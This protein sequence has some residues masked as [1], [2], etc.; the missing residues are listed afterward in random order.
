LLGLGAG[1]VY[2]LIALGVVLVYR[3][4]G[5]LN[6]AQG[7][8][9]MTGAFMF[10]DLQ[11]SAGWPL[12]AAAVAAAMFSAAL[13]I[14]I[15]LL[16]MRRLRDSSGLA[17]LIA[18]LA[19]WLFLRG[20]AGELWGFDA[21]LPDRILPSSRVSLLNTSVGADRLIVCGVAIALTIVLGLVYRFTRF[22]IA[23]EAVAE[24]PVASAALGI[25]PHFL[26]S[27]N[28]ALGS[29]LA[30][31][32]A[33]LIVPISGLQVDDLTFLVIPGLAAALVG[34][35]R[36]YS[37]TLLG[38]LAL[39]IAESETSRYVSDPGWTR[40][41]PF[42]V[43]VLV[44]VIRGRALPVRGEPNVRA[45]EV[46][47][48]RI[49][50]SWLAVGIAGVALVIFVA[51]DDWTA[52]LITTFSVGLVVLSIV[53][54]TGYC[55]QLSLAQFAVAGMGAWAAGRLVANYG[56]PMPVAALIAVV[57]AVPVGLVIAV[58]A[59]RTR[60][61]NL[62]VAT[63]GLA[64]VIE[65]LVLLNSKRTGGIDGTRVGD[66]KLFG[67]D[68]SGATHP[69][70]YAALAGVVFLLAAVGVANVRRGPSGRRYIAVRAN[71]R[72]AAA[73]GI[74][75]VETKMFAFAIAA[76]IA[77]LGGVLAAFRYPLVT[78]EQFSLFQSIYAVVVAVLGGVG[79][80][81]GSLLGATL[82]PG[83]IGT[84]IGDSL[85][86]SIETQLQ[87]ITPLVLLVMLRREPNGFAKQ[88]M[89][90]LARLRRLTRRGV[91]P[92]DVPPPVAARIESRP[93]AHRGTPTETPKSLQVEGLSVS[94]G[95]TRALENVSFRVTPG[96]VVG[97]IGANGAGK[98]TLIDA[99]TGFVKPSQGTVVLGDVDI[100]RWSPDRRARAGVS[101]SFQ[102]LELFDSLS[103]RDNLHVACDSATRL[104]FLTDLVHPARQS[105]SST[106][107]EAIDDFGLG[108]TLDRRPDDLPYAT[109]RLVAIARAVATSPSVLLLD[110]PA[111]GLDDA[112][113]AELSILIRRLAT[114]WRLAVIVVEHDMSLVLK[115]CDRIEVLD[116]GRH[117]ASGTPEEIRHDQ[118]VLDAYLGAAGDDASERGA[119][120][121]QVRAP[122]ARENCERD[123]TS[124][125]SGA[126]VLH[127]VHVSAG[128][129]DLAAVR[130]VDLEVHA[131]E[132]VAIIGSNGAGKTTT[133]RALAGE[134]P[135]LAGEIRWNDRPC[136]GPM[137]QRARRGLAF[138]PEGR[139]VFVNLSVAANLR[140]G[141]GQSADALALFPELQALLSRR[142]GLL[143]GG[144][145][146]ILSVARALAS[147][148]S[149]LLADELSIGLAPKIVD[150]LFAEIRR[151]ADDGVAAI[152]VDQS[153]ERVLDIAD[154]VVVLS[155]GLVV[156]NEPA[157]ALRG[158]TAAI[159]ESFLGA[160]ERDQIPTGRTVDAQDARSR[161]SAKNRD[162]SLDNTLIV[163]TKSTN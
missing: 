22:G 115:T 87:I 150:R 7:A 95:H 84:Q 55:G 117:L 63:L 116:Q 141:R 17:A 51:S 4:S 135:L 25:S 18:T 44:L 137:H 48:G 71:E 47:T 139:S 142:G 49:S 128:Y 130:D 112:E 32:G 103:V 96:E 10:Y 156:A 125:A 163:E 132:I 123:S 62:A 94:F 133:L 97:V 3:G 76:A 72:G 69:A 38:G 2:A 162:E 90:D 11:S 159:F 78:F 86:G 35:F 30:T 92:D 60:G 121:H 19:V 153:V 80:V 155:R 29:L 119:D 100:S 75:V 111:A 12:A 46:G 31:A 26:A 146:Q 154:R 42:L 136:T 120:E 24:N 73:L 9:G 65:R 114:Q 53:V 113:T 151:A 50:L 16:V 23:T 158:K 54:V 145:Q 61:M 118:A 70:R 127:A 140:L 82:V 67:W 138:V 143:S 33:I 66:T 88:L 129:G 110:E 21:R 104:V 37:L 93:V 74:S 8:I 106:A 1:G 77:A 20:I 147:K 41:A 39:G 98:T 149:V 160:L 13:G 157:S 59:L 148:P 161:E 36:S 68:I 126:S 89:K 52:S 43:I 109:R 40:A 81:L 14:A 15:H 131:G 5:V 108:A 107:Q 99:I 6:F 79:F 101:R 85:F 27:V 28:W 58:P 152:V 64:V 122:S 34:G 83:A 91:E 102:S 134:L 144:E 56:T 124:A 105:M 45:P 57:C